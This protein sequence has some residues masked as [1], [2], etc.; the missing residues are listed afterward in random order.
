LSFDPDLAA[1]V[2]DGRAY[3]TDGVGRPIEPTSSVEPG[4]ILRV[5]VSARRGVREEE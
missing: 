2:S 1:A 3:V 5:V 4:A